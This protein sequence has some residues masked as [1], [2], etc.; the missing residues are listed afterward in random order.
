MLKLNH[1]HFKLSIRQS[2]KTEGSFNKMF[3]DRTD[4]S[5]RLP[6]IHDENGLGLLIYNEENFLHSVIR[7][8]KQKR[9]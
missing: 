8:E 2:D 9:N 5:Y 1:L 3:Y 4:Y 7:H 6:S